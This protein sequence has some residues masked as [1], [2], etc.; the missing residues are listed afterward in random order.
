MR[1]SAGSSQNYVYADIN[2]D[3]WFYFEDETRSHPQD[4][5]CNKSHS[6]R[7][8]GGSGLTAE[9]AGGSDTTLIGFK[10]KTRLTHKVLHDGACK[11]AGLKPSQMQNLD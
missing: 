1:A 4:E 9:T 6:K 2:G 8:V 11:F 5:E 10:H 3:D 7:R